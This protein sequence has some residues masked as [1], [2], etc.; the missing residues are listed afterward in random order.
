[1]DGLKWHFASNKLTIWFKCHI[2]LQMANHQN[3]RWKIE[4][5][6]GLHGVFSGWHAQ[7]YFS[8]CFSLLSSSHHVERLVSS[9]LISVVIGLLV[10]HL[11][12]EFENEIITLLL[13]CF[14]FPPPG[15]ACFAVTWPMNWKWNWTTICKGFYAQIRGIS[16][17]ALENLI[18]LFFFSNFC[19]SFCSLLLST[20]VMNPAICPN[21]SGSIS[22]FLLNG[23]PRKGAS[24]RDLMSFLTSVGHDS[25]CENVDED[26]P[27][28]GID[29]LYNLRQVTVSFA[30]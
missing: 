10:C 5:S 9:V 2:T 3:T 23:N 19:L 28:R 6:R 22:F 16:L 12:E 25:P 20:V 17:L 18:F 14:I 24:S 21:R 15:G 27:W 1:M 13:A 7:S 26:D 8:P 4:W 29:D 30:I 11:S